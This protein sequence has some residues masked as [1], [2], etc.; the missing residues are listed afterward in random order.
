LAGLQQR[1]QEAILVGNPT[2]GLFAAEGE[3][4]PGGFT[5]Y[6][7]AYHSRLTA[8]LRDNFPVLHRALGDD[9]FGA[10]ARA[11]IDDH[12][13]HFR[14]IRWFGDSLVGFLEATPERLPHA[15]LVDLARMDWATRAAFDAADAALLAMSELAALRPEDWPSQ[16]FTPVPSL[17]VLDLAWQVEPTWKALNA[18]AEAATEEPQMLPH[19]LLVWR[20]A[21]DCSWRS[22]DASEA[23]AL[24][25]LTRAA[26]FAEC[27]TV[28]AESGEPEPANVAAG[29]LQRWVSEGLLARGCPS[30]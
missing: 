21:L 8:A 16:R 13:S 28:I 12:P 25:A 11:Y 22:A 18:D 3:A 26:T 27:C 14:S 10:L 1:F 5:V 17:Q 23:A 2:P 24:R 29:F 19:V 7:H 4:L 6:L 30:P 20:P 15:A 9:A